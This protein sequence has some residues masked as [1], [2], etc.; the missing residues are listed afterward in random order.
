MS[1]VRST[2]QAARAQQQR[3]PRDTSIGRSKAIPGIHTIGEDFMPCPQCGEP[4][5]KRHRQ[6]G[7]RGDA[8]T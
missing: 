1:E 6:R 8:A 4:L 7:H 3:T 5:T 2:Q